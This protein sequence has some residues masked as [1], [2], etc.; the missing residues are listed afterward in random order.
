[1]VLVNT[2]DVLD[3]FVRDI[4]LGLNIGQLLRVTSSAAP[5]TDPHCASLVQ[6]LPYGPVDGLRGHGLGLPG[7]EDGHALEDGNDGDLG[8]PD[9]DHEG[10]L[11][12]Q[13]EEGHQGRRGVEHR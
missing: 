3:Y 13:C 1:M 7:L 10:G 4:H 5:F 6:Q 11:H 8:V 2:F 12:T 9:V